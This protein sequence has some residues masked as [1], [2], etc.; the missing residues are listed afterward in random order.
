MLGWLFGRDRIRELETKLADANGLL[1][2]LDEMWKASL[3]E[4]QQ[5]RLLITALRDVNATLD[6]RCNEMEKRL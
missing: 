4:N 3:K 1:A 6:A 5:Q 2:K